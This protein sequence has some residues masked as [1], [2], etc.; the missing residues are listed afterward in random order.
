[1]WFVGYADGKGQSL[2][3][4]HTIIIVPS[5]SV[6]RSVAAVYWVNPMISSSPDDA[7]QPWGDY[8]ESVIASPIPLSIKGNGKLRH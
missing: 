3:I 5:E 8:T 1:M 2:N 4:N 6:S 7:M